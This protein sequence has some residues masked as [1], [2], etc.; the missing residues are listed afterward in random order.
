MNWKSGI[1][2]TFSVVTAMAVAIGFMP[3]ESK[4]LKDVDG[5]PVVVYGLEEYPTRFWSYVAITLAGLMLLAFLFVFYRK[6]KI[7][8]LNGA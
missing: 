1:I 6:R 4:D 8:K 5:N 3:H 7:R 2:W